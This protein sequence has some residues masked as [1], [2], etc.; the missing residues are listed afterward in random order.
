MNVSCS[1]CKAKI[2]YS[3]RGFVRGAAFTNHAQLA[4]NPEVGRGGGTRN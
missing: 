3:S 4:D 1:S 2:N